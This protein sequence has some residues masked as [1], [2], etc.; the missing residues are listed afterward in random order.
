MMQKYAVAGM[1]SDS[2][3][4]RVT[5]I[6]DYGSTILTGTKILHPGKVLSL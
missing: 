4:F 6:A 1:I 2:L 3:I 5:E